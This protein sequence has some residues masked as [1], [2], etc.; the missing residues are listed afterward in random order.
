MIRTLSRDGESWISSRVIRWIAMFALMSS[1][2]SYGQTVSTNIGTAKAQASIQ[3]AGSSPLAIGDEPF[4]LFDGLVR[5]LRNGG[6]VLYLRHGAVLPGSQDQRG[7]GAWWKNCSGTQRLAPEALP[8]ARAIGEALQRQRIIVTE[9]FSSEFCRAIDTAIHLG[10]SAATH[11]A[12]LN[13]AST[14]GPGG[15]T[16]LAS[17]IQELLSRPMTPRTNRILVGHALPPTLVHPALSTLPEGHSAL[18]KAEG[19][20]RFHFITALSPGQWQWIGRQLVSDAPTAA[21]AVIAPAAAVSPPPPPVIDASKELKGMALIQALR[22]GGMNL[23]MRH[24]QA[25]VGQDGNLA[26]T[27]AWWENCAI[28][29][30]LSDAGRDQARKVGEA[31]RELKIPVAKVLA[32]QFCRTRETAHL[33]NLG[34]IEVTEDINHQI[35]QRAGFDINVSRYRRLTEM[36]ANASNTMLVSHTH[37]SPRPEERIMSGIQEAEVVVYRPDGKG[38]SE[39]IARIPPAEWENLVKLATG[40]P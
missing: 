10:L 32:A 22:K 1:T 9:V 36:P 39:P 11:S 2:A 15:Y 16:Q 3:Q 40:K 5:E 21:A 14:L 4:G 34:P 18:F 7:A 38:G 29:R 37:G 12:A 8:R 30:N 24:A 31:M 35:G 27:P 13:D 25:N 17:G 28:Q 26:Q 6:Y 19:S 33:L 20:G 23:Y